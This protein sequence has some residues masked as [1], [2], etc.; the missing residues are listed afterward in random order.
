MSLFDVFCAI[1]R[2]FAQLLDVVIKTAVE[3]IT[4][5]ADA[6]ITLL[7]DVL[8]GVG[9]VIGDLLSTPGGILLLGLGAFLLFS[10]LQRKSN[11]SGSETVEIVNPDGT[12]KKT[13]RSSSSESSYA[14]A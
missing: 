2:F 10:M 5:V 4:E 3:V 13:S 9:G 14:D 11:S 8:E 7:D 1:W 12:S 6:A